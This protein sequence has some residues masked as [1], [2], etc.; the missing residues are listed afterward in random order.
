MSTFEPCAETARDFRDVLG[1]FGTGV[2]VVT[3]QCPEG[4]VGMT[5]NS[6]AS[7]SLDPPLVL[8]SPALASLRFAHFEA[9]SHYAI[10]VLRDD[11]AD[12]ARRFARDAHA[13]DGLDW[14]RGANDL[15]LIEGCLARFECRQHA[16]H[17]GG[18]HMILVGRVL[19]A[20][21]GTGAPLL[22]AQGSYG[23]FAPARPNPDTPA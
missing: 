13:F 5:A 1:Q 19:R 16:A 14:R 2:T 17:E 22:F 20:T 23:A 4:P 3:T 10:H 6:F 18:D 12:L 8:W 11:Q 15:P 7:V 21:M 9:A